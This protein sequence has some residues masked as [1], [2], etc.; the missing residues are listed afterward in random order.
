MKASIAIRIHSLRSQYVTYFNVVSWDYNTYLYFDTISN[1]LNR[2][3]CVFPFLHI[4]MG[5]IYCTAS[6]I[7]NRYGQTQCV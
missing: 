3:T 1:I 7:N 4:N 6:R 5:K 2:H